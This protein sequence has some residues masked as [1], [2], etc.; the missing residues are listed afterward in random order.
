MT[1]R[2]VTAADD[3]SVPETAES[4]GDSASPGRVTRHLRFALTALATAS[5]VVL[6]YAPIPRS[7]LPVILGI[8]AIPLLWC[9]WP[10]HA[11]AAR[12]LLRGRLTS[13][14]LASLALVGAAAWG[15]AA[16][17]SERGRTEAAEALLAACALT[18]ALTFSHLLTRTV[19]PPAQPMPP[20][21]VT[22]VLG[23]TLATGA[24]WA[25]LSSPRAG[26]AAGLAVLVVA[27]PA[28]LTLAHG[29]V[30][31]TMRR[32]AVRL[33]VRSISPTAAEAAATLD[34][35]VLDKHGTVTTGE[36]RVASIDPFDPGHER[37]MRWF[38][39][40]LEQ[41][42]DDPI[43]RAL[44][45]PLGRGRLTQVDYAPGR[46]LSGWVDR[47][48]VRVGHPDWV[49]LDA[50]EQLGTTIGVEVDGRLLGSITLAD[51]LRD[52]APAA[53]VDLG[54][55]GLTPVLVSGD[56][57]ADVQDAA[58]RVGIETAVAEAGAERRAEVVDELRAD[59]HRVAFVGAGDANAPA[60]TRAE[61][62]VT[63]DRTLTG[64]A[65]VLL[66]DV[67]I[68]RV[69]AVLRLLR[70]SRPRHSALR[71][72]AYVAAVA[73][74]P[75]AAAGLLGLAGS[76]LVMGATSAALTAAGSVPLRA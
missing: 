51:V 29:S 13:A 7:S 21:W 60:A 23:A 12:S 19:E 69:G 11:D 44:A 3:S 31:A 42:R 22:L 46:G 28:A 30:A 71:A 48:P 14:L 8:A 65:S 67:A 49:G 57:T 34:T 37:N 33:G 36:L 47:H 43:G 26:L 53:I 52:E 75:F 54:R 16:A 40:A 39:G 9:A 56:R 4:S 55:A 63:H 64:R 61:L 15:V 73:A 58:A 10:V 66:Q 20:W 1:T 50:P 68:D 18:L 17:L 24:S 27:S 35:V 2:S 62:L 45:R 32:Q 25:A 41:T 5:L 74:M 6:L 72:A 70:A 76:T 59:Q 38:A